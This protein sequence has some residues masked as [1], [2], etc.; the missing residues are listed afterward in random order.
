MVLLKG[1]LE[2]VYP[3]LED[4]KAL[5]GSPHLLCNAK[6]GQGQLKLII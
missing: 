6:I 5:K 1:I 3:K 2:K 4:M